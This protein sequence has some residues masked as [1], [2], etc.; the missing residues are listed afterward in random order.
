MG[1]FAGGF[2]GGV[3]A[4]YLFFDSIDLLGLANGGEEDPLANAD[5]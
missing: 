3:L 5:Y 2:R 4:F 1:P